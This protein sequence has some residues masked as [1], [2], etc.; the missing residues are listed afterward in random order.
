ML[1]FSF[2]FPSATRLQSYSKNACRGSIKKKKSP[3][4]EE[5]PSPKIWLL[6]TRLP[7]TPAAYLV[8]RDKGVLEEGLHDHREVLALQVLVP[9]GEPGDA[10]LWV[11]REVLDP[12][13]KNGQALVLPP[14]GGHHG[15]RRPWT[16]V[17]LKGACRSS[18]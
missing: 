13:G 15:G 8:Q 12:P 14:G 7:D 4:R 6:C 17:T 18:I 10:A 5:N 2:S 11:G 16:K 3:H 9:V 1:V